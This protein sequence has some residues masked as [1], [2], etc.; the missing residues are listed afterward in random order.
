LFRLVFCAYAV[1][2]VLQ[3]Y[4]INIVFHST[5]LIGNGGHFLCYLTN[6]T[7]TTVGLYAIMS[8]APYIWPRLNEVRFDILF[9][10]KG[11]VR[12]SLFCITLTSTFYLSVV[13]WGVLGLHTDG[14]PGWAKAWSLVDNIV[15]HGSNVAWLLL[16][17]S[18]FDRSLHR[19]FSLKMIWPSVIF[20]LVY[21]AVSTGEGIMTGYY[22]YFFLEPDFE[23]KGYF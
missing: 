17:A 2:G 8:A 19:A 13:F 12:Q 7:A 16:D 10:P 22:P 1:I 5:D 6:L 20:G 15:V 18:V 21:L 11:P 9:H 23:G 14:Y 3:S 4:A